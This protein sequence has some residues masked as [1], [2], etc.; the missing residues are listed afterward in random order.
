MLKKRFR[1]YNV[2]LLVLAMGCL[3]Y[4]DCR[5]GL[6]LKGVTSA[7]FAALGAVNL[8]YGQ[9]RRCGRQR[10]L[11]LAELALVLGMAADV[12]LGIQF[13]VGVVVFALGH[14]SYVAAFCAVEKPSRRDLYV[15]LP[16]GVLSVFL[17][18]GTP[19]IQVEDPALKIMLTAYAVVIS[20]MLGKVVGNLLAERT[21]SRR[22]MAIGGALF[23]FS[24]LMLALNLFGSGGKAASILC[25]YT[26]WPGQSILAHSLFHYVNEE[27][28]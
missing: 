18:L 3:V 20:C 28:A 22:L 1:T 8:W 2:I 5:G 12:L 27:T 17:A 16:I 4:Y 14:V 6:W 26:Y 24:D 11:G 10:V 23:W 15:A 7:W 13:L 21:L 9:K 19:Y 25:M